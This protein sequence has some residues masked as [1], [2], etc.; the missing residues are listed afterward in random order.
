MLDFIFYTPTKVFF[1]KDKESDVGEIIAS[2]GYKTIMMQYGKN[3]IKKSGLYDRV[4]QSLN[5]H[6]IKVVEMGGVEP[7]PKLS[8]VREAVKKAQENNAEM[9]LAVGGGSVLD[10]SKATAVAV[11]SDC[12]I[13]DVITGK[14]VPKKALPVGAILTISAAGSEMSSSAVITN[15]ELNMKR[16]FNSD[17]NRCEFAILNPELTRSVGPYQTACGVVDIMAHTMERYF[18]VC[19]PTDVTDRISESIL[20]AVIEGA[21]VLIDDPENYE[22]RANVMWASSLSHNGLTACGRINA[23]P[24][25]QLEHGLSGEFDHI[26]HGAGLAVLFPAW[27]R[28]SYKEN[29]SRF[30]Q[31]ARRVFGV[32]DDDDLSASVKG[33]EK[34]EE[35]FKTI[36][37]PLKLREFEISEDSL[38]KIAELTTFN[39]TRTI[40]SYIELDY[41]NVLKI[42]ESC[43]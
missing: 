32:T 7:N 39:K 36:N 35:F 40:K 3:S 38:T 9:I 34:L 5:K 12:D 15:T 22:A 4:M 18:T 37:M 26:S 31:F 41:D 24:V 30:A 8:F 27:M 20:K 16:G 1:G 21:K 14:I 43:Y 29:P 13:W 2:Y 42:L 11:G 23:L 19:E 6:N 33:I 28:F 25:H 17:L 10:S